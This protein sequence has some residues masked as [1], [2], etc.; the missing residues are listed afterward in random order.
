VPGAAYYKRSLVV[1]P[2]A[3]DENGHVNNVEFIRWMQD[4]AIA[5]SDHVGGTAATRAC[6]AAWF[7]R[8]HHIEYVRPAYAGE[9]LSVITWVASRVRVRS[10]RRYC[11][12][13]DSDR[14]VLARGKTVW[15]FVDQ[16]T[17]KPRSI[18]KEVDAC[19]TLAVDESEAAAL[20]WLKTTPT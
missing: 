3:I 7:A 9:H 13:R 6:G 1:P 12:V 19:Y 14:A 10:E 18:P 20:A 16:A 11:V 5:H 15:I 17:Q 2:S 4:A 8:E